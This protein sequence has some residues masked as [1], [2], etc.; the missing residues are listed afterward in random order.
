MKNCS[1]REEIHVVKNMD[2]LSDRPTF[3]V[4]INTRHSTRE[5]A[6]IEVPTLSLRPARP[7]FLFPDQGKQITSSPKHPEH[8]ES[9]PASDNLVLVLSQELNR[10][11]PEFYH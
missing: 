10:P 4:M 6:V 7:Q 3:L 11:G 8:P 1:Y 5:S 9:H 2:V